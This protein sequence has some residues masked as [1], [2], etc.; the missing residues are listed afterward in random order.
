MAAVVDP[1]NGQRDGHAV[2]VLAEVVLIHSLGD[3][4]EEIGFVG[5]ACFAIEG[6]HEVA[7]CRLP[8]Q[9]FGPVRKGLRAFHARLLVRSRERQA[10][11]DGKLGRVTQNIFAIYRLAFARVSSPRCPSSPC[12]RA[13][14]VR[15][16]CH[17]PS[18]ARR[19]ASTLYWTPSAKP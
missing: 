3:L 17:A 14:S 8:L 18:S 12:Y 16:C 19:V 1:V 6:R 2:L 15:D 4:V 10:N 7:V 5:G 13:W 9:L 11:G